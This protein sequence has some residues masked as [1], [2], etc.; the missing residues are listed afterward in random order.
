[1]MDMNTFIAVLLAVGVVVGILGMIL[2]VAGAVAVSI[3][4]ADT[5]ALPPA[6][7][8]PKPSS[9]PRQVWELLPRKLLGGPLDVCQWETGLSRTDT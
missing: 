9:T 1:M 5:S 2:L 3:V 8:A 4:D 7:A 6:P